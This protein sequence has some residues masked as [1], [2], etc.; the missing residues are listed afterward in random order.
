MAKKLKLNFDGFFN[1]A[2]YLQDSNGVNYLLK[3]GNTLNPPIDILH[4][5]GTPYS[6]SRNS[7]SGVRPDLINGGFHAYYTHYR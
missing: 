3:F 4:G 5:K 7:M 1:Y 2:D 6:D